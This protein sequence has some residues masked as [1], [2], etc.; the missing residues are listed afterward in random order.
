MPEKCKTY[1]DGEAGFGGHYVKTVVCD[2][3]KVKVKPVAV[4]SVSTKDQFELMLEVVNAL[5][6]EAFSSFKSGY[7]IK[8]TETPA[9][10][11]EKCYWSGDTGFGGLHVKTCE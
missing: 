8:K 3:P 5:I 9:Q 2:T 11:T 1:Y 7:P 6:K 10:K 4:N